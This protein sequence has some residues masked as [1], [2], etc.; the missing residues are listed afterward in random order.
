M[1]QDMSAVKGLRLRHFRIVIAL[2][3]EK[4]VTRA[5]GRL[6]VTQ[7]AVSKAL[8]EIER[9][10]GARLFDRRGRGLDATPLGLRVIAAARRIQT[11]LS[12]LDDEVGEMLSGTSGTVKV[13]VQTISAQSFIAHAVSAVKADA[14]HLDIHLTDGVLSEHLENLRAGEL[15]LVFGRIAP[16]LLLPDLD[17]YAIVEDATVVVAGPDHP[18]AGNPSLMLEDVVDQ[19][20]ILSPPGTPM[21]DHFRRILAER[22]LALPID[23]VETNGTLMTLTFLHETKRLGLLPER[24]ARQWADRGVIRTLPLRLDGINA[25]IGLIV[26]RDRTQG[27]AVRRFVSIVRGEIAALG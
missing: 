2:A 7:A 18:L 13:G 19:A 4:S 10:L 6:F 9:I 11:E 15:D 22:G 25:P 20:W 23:R 8:A 27:P 21:R 17:G 16:E 24:F 3:D 14:P 26:P 1:E 12:V 5:A